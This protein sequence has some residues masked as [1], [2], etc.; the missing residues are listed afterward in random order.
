MRAD[1][2]VG[3]NI[4][5]KRLKIILSRL[6]LPIIFYV[7]WGFHYIEV[8]IHVGMDQQGEYSVFNFETKALPRESSQVIIPTLSLR[9]LPLEFT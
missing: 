7:Q 8:E 6:S 9:I 5:A 4:W 2:H 3:I 1:R